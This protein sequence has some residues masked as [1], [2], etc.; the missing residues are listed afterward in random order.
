[1]KI[2]SV[3][4]PIGYGGGENQLV[5]LAK[6][7]RKIGA[8]FKILNLVKSEEFENVLRKNEITYYTLSNIKIGFGLSQKGYLKLF[9]KL[10]PYIMLNR[11]IK[12]LIDEVDVV[13]AHGFPANACVFL[14]LK[15]GILSKERKMIYSHHFV[16]S[17]MKG[18]LRLVYERILNTF[19]V[20][21]GVSSR[22][23]QSLIEVFP[24][25]K[26]KIVTIPNGIDIAQFNIIDSKQELR[27]GLNLPLHDIL[28]IYVARFVPFKNHIFIL[29]VL[30]AIAKDDFKIVLLGDGSEFE[31]FMLAARSA[32]SRGLDKRIICPGFVPNNLV[33]LYL[34]ASDI[35]VFPSLAEGFGVS[36]LEA[37]AAGLPTVIF[38]N[39]YIEEFG[40]N[41]LVANNDKEFIDF[42]KRLVEDAE[43]RTKVGEGCSKDAGKLS[44]ENTVRR[45]L[46]IFG[47]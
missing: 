35:C 28:G 34:K 23:S 21:V 11:K 10:I 19:D 32:R 38:K 45:Y 42:V 6:E 16:K 14:M 37:V 24:R 3:I 29:D 22:T 8:D 20:I 33:P 17:P 5:L 25:L 9:F 40:E 30:S 4:T 43:Y 2:L 44:I 27:M 15:M 18:I 46:E 13:W 26:E 47:G 39:V 36:I 1:M 41:I 7:F 12:S 31:R